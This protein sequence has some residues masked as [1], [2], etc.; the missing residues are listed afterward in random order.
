[1]SDRNCLIADILR[2][3]RHMTGVSWLGNKKSIETTLIPN[4]PSAGKAPSGPAFNVLP[5]MPSMRGTHGPWISASRISILPEPILAKA[6]ARFTVTIVLPTPPL[7]LITAILCFTLLILSLSLLSC[8]STVFIPCSHDAF[9]ARYSVIFPFHLVQCFIFFR[10]IL[11]NTIRS[12]F[13]L[14]F[15]TVYLRLQVRQASF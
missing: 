1:M 2:G 4:G 8:S 9:S 10:L 7:P 14:L 12:E 3:P 11:I 13:S 15:C 5:F 6:M